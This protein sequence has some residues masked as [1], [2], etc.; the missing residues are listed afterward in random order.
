MQARVVFL[1]ATFAL[2]GYFL[3]QPGRY[4]ALGVY[5]LEDD[6][7]DLAASD[8]GIQASH[9]RLIGIVLGQ[10]FVWGHEGIR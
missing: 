4:F 8:G 7:D 9:G 2:F 10:I 6:A 3:G 5:S 1:R